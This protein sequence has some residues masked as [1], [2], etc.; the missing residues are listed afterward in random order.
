MGLLFIVF[1]IASQLKIYKGRGVLPALEKHGYN[2]YV[3]R[4]IE[5]KEKA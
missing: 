5:E 2:E 3:L 4:K 1:Y